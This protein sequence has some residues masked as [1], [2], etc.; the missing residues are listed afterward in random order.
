MYCAPLIGTTAKNKI[1]HSIYKKKR[2]KAFKIVGLTETKTNIRFYSILISKIR[3]HSTFFDI[4][5]DLVC[6]IRYPY[7]CTD[8]VYIVIDVCDCVW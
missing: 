7:D 6:T 8:H 1:M 3:T 2:K 4:L 5:V